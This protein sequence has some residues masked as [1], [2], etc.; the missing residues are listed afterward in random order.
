MTLPSTIIY[1]DASSSETIDRGTGPALGGNSPDRRT[2]EGGRQEYQR[3]AGQAGSHHRR[4][5][6]PGGIDN[7]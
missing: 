1:I 5:K 2:A 7:E 4:S 3:I 6:Q